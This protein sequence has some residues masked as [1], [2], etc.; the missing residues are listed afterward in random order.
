MA[1]EIERLEKNYIALLGAIPYLTTAQGGTILGAADAATL[2]D[3]TTLSPP[4][5]VVVFNSEIAQRNEIVGGALQQTSMEWSI[6]LVA[7][8]FGAEVEGRLGSTG[9]YQMIDDALAALEGK[10]IS[11]DE[12]A[13]VFYVRTRRYNVTGNAVVYELVVRNAYLRKA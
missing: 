6:F 1:S 5:A 10:V 7:P 13:K 12:T 2:L 11:L 8:S 3:L 4:A 9:V